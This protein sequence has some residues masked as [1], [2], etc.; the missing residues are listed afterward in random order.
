MLKPCSKTW[1]LV[2]GLLALT[3]GAAAADKPSAWTANDLFASPTPYALG[4]RGYGANDGED[5]SRPLANTLDA[6]HQ[7]FGDGIR[8]VELDLQRTADAKVVVY[9]DDWVGADSTCV[10]SLTYDELLVQKPEVPLFGAVLNSCRHF[11]YGACLSGIVF[12]EIKVP[13]PFCDG[14]NTSSQAEASESEL[15]A[16][17]VAEIRKA[18]MED[19]VILNS[20]SPTILRQA[21]L[22]APEIKRALTLNVLQ[23]VDPA[24]VPALTGMPVALIPKNDF[25]LPWYNVG[26]IA[27][28]PSFWRSG[29]SGAQIFQRFVM[30]TL[31][32]GSRAVSLDELVL[33]QAGAGAPTIVAGLHGV[34][35][36]VVVWTIASAADWSFAAQA[37]ADGITTN[38]IALGLA[39]QA[40]LPG[41]TE[42]AVANSP[43]LAPTPDARARG[44]SARPELALELS[45]SNPS[46][47]GSARLRFALPE[48]SAVELAVYDISGRR[49]A[50]LMSGTC[51]AGEHEA[52]WRLSDDGGRPVASG[53]YLASLRVGARQLTRRVVVV[54]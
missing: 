5:P 14:A 25:G 36:K 38:D 4:H 11:G 6:F 1:L 49:I 43:S 40:P 10:S 13:I 45:G 35:L 44:S 16:A 7:A 12:A 34:G 23:L 48:R 29:E 47:D 26:E 52:A 42:V 22:Q 2:C 17:V 53:V 28:L 15:V 50:K 24:L 8:V 27:R 21:A 37:G 9:H 33:F 20:G 39:R 31:A 41:C 54:H 46:R 32:V 3:W 51:A 18:R 30:T 19:Q